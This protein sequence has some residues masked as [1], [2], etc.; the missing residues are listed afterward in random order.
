MSK[1]HVDQKSIKNILSD[2]SSQYLIPEYQRPYEWDEEKCRTLWED[3]LEFAMPDNNPDN[4]D[5]KEEYYLGSIVTFKNG[6]VL[7]VI[8]GQ[9]RITT[10]LLLLRAIYKKLEPAKDE[11]SVYLKKEIEPCIWQ[12]DGIPPKPN[13]D[14]IRIDTKV[15]TDK[16]R[17]A[18]IDIL[19]TGNVSNGKNNYSLNYQHFITWI[20]EYVT[21]YPI[22][23]Y[24]LCVRILNN[25]ILLPIEC[26]SQ[27]V[28]LRIFT[29]LNDRGMPL[30]D[31]DIFKAQLYKYYS[32]DNKQDSFIQQ[33]QELSEI[34]DDITKY[35]RSNQNAIDEI[36]TL[37][38]YW[39]RAKNSIK[40]TTVPGLRKYFE[41]DKY[42]KLKNDETMKDVISLSYF[43]KVLFDKETNNNIGISEETLKY[44]HSLEHMPN[45]F[46]KYNLTVYFFAYKDEN[47]KLNEVE[48]SEFTK[49]TLAYCFVS[50]ITKPGLSYI[51]NASIPVFVDIADKKPFKYPIFDKTDFERGFHNIYTQSKLM[52]KPVLLWE[53]YQNLEQ[54]IIGKDTS[55]KKIKLEIEHILPKNWKSGYYKEWNRGDAD[56]Y[57]EKLG[58]KIILDKKT[59]IQAGDGFFKTK[60]ENYYVKSPI[61]IV[62]E[63]AEE[64]Q[65]DDWIKADIIKREDTLL[66]NFIEFAKKHDIIKDVNI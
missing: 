8:D 43:W 28:A 16:D 52:I 65:H 15:A 64:Y 62:N 39:L 47:N 48:F 56:E 61:K 23:F 30:S 57:L 44:V 50:Y 40:D 34:C 55:G 27:D 17:G 49:K 58:N 42:Q 36:F 35:Q 29:T 12:T 21:S 53:A 60:K 14:K 11:E 59:N 3:I 38:M 32:N 2:K 13:K 1:L 33:W 6:D 63:L 4:F 51:K 19:K 45:A 24:S 26:E 7:E 18:F 46:W 9:Q 37:Y 66:E 54:S 20:D 31:S 10:L 22:P 41:Q 25:C 5:S